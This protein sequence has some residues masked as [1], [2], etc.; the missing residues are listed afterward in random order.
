MTAT[1]MLEGDLLKYFVRHLEQ[2]R[3]MLVT[4]AG[5]SR[6]AKDY[7]G[8]PLPIGLDLARDLWSIAFPSDIFEENTSL[9]D[10]FSVALQRD[11]K[12]TTQLLK[13]RLSVDSAS[14]GENYRLWLSMAWQ[15]IYTFNV[16]DL[17]IAAARVFKD[18]P[19]TPRTLS[20]LPDSTELGNALDG[21]KFLPV[22]HLHGSVADDPSRL[23]FA[24]HQYAHRSGDADAGYA[25]MMNEL[26]AYPT[27]FVGTQLDEQ[28]FWQ[29]IANRDARSGF[30]VKEARPKC[31]L[32]LPGLN[33]AREALLRQYNTVLVRGTGAEFAEKVLKNL[34]VE[35][36]AGLSAIAERSTGQKDS[37]RN[38][39][40]VRGTCEREKLSK[41]SDYLVGQEPTWSDLISGRIIAREGDNDIFKHAIDSI[42]Q[43]N[44]ART[45]QDAEAH[46]ILITGTAGTGK[47][48]TMRRLAYQVAAEGNPVGWIDVDTEIA[49]HTLVN[50]ARDSKFFPVLF[51]D[52]VD[53]YGQTSPGLLRDLARSPGIFLVV[54]SLRSSKVAELESDPALARAN[55]CL[56][57]MASLSDGDI[58]GLLEVLD[59]ER[60]LGELAGL[61]PQERVR[62][63]Q[64]YA[65][66]QLLV[67]M[68][69]A[70]S[71]RKLEEKVCSEWTDL[72]PASKMLY[73]MI[74]VATTLRYR[75]SESELLLASDAP[76]APAIPQELKRLWQ[77]NIVIRDKENLRIRARHRVIAERLFDEL[78]RQHQN[79][80]A[81]AIQRLGYSVAT[82]IGPATPEG[83]APFRFLK[84]LMNHDF[85]SRV[86][87]LHGAR[88]VFQK[89]AEPLAGWN[90]HY[91]LQRGSLEVEVGDIREAENSL[92][93]ARSIA[94]HDGFVETEYA[95]MLVKKAIS[96]RS[97]TS[98]PRLFAE[99]MSLLRE[100]TR[101]GKRKDPH[102]FHII[103]KQ[104]IVWSRLGGLNPTQQRD[105]LK[106]AEDDVRTGLRLHPRSIELQ[107]VKQELLE[108]LMALRL[109]DEPGRN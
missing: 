14:L 7:E 19:R 39:V 52:D 74:A 2:G 101:S 4:G 42:E 85:L 11:K 64:G 46:V 60:R 55:K 48:S 109:L 56:F 83:T 61:P 37:A 43:T 77:T 81:E 87:G 45:T 33:A 21:S 29:Q 50:A 108:A 79:T 47:S 93:Q 97:A 57:T 63:L 28:I 90:H 9:Q 96:E 20:G 107:N 15:K 80:L 58:S 25:L 104:S 72:P 91:W 67:A 27:V 40:D 23:T 51:I 8:R 86:L 18:L 76:S 75:V 32:I 66:R 24:R 88:D 89:L 105:L 35:A 71:G 10:V 78:Q 106:L 17:E 73:A 82:G 3:L 16:D 59:R 6:D 12:A 41:T 1:T 100:Q 44:A 34:V 38:V 98:A 102:P 94:P 26:L 13:S 99:G 84:T 54:A 92:A 36:K 31:F 22:I 62:R 68:I 65:G 30:G 103:A 70:T 53:R 69:E 95:Y 5:F 49:P